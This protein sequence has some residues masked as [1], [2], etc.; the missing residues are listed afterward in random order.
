MAQV[1]KPKWYVV[2]TGHVPGVYTSWDV[3]QRQISGFPKAQYK[4]YESQAAAE[5]A[6]AEGPIDLVVATS[7]SSTPRV[8]KPTHDRSGVVLPSISVDAACNMTT[9]VMEYRGVDTETEAEFFRM[10][11]YEDSSNN[12]GE[13]LA[14]VHALAHCKKHN[15]TLP[16]YSDSRTAIAWVRNRH[17]KTTLERT[18]K[19]ARVFELIQRAED[20]LCTN[21]YVNHILKWETELWGENPADFG[22][23]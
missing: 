22:R 13:F 5:R 6:F 17:A 7:R 9:G 3:A 8:P 20:W 11:P 19:N 10:G 4:S 18:A 1:K 12:M 21:T 2:W 15:I 16:I 14:I 23:K